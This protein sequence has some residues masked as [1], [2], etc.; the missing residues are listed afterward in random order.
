MV[1]FYVLLTF[2]V[3][4]TMIYRVE[5][6]RNYAAASACM[7]W[8]VSIILIQLEKLNFLQTPF[9]KCDHGEGMFQL[10]GIVGT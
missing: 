9:L 7:Y 4:D 10:E 1:Y 8:H 3:T 5:Q 6:G 2:H